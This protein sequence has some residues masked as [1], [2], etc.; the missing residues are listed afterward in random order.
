MLTLEKFWA[1]VKNTCFSKFNTH[2]FWQRLYSSR[3]FWPM[4]KIMKNFITMLIFTNFRHKELDTNTNKI[5]G[6]IK[7]VWFFVPKV[8]TSHVLAH[9][10]WRNAIARE[11]LSQWKN[12]MK[13]LYLNC[14][15][16]RIN[17]Q[18]SQY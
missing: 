14:N 13:F 9:W 8:S 11:S 10:F 5:L 1:M 17:V 15:I 16:L 4:A 7:I 6:P 18:R 3:N 12:I 2:L